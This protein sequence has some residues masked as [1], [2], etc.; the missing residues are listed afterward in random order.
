MQIRVGKRLGTWPDVMVRHAGGPRGTSVR[1]WPVRQRTSIARFQAR[2]LMECNE[3]G[4]GSK[5]VYPA[6]QP[7]CRCKAA[8]PESPP[9]PRQY[10]AGDYAPPP[11]IKATWRVLSAV[12]ALRRLEASAGDPPEGSERWGKAATCARLCASRLPSARGG[13]REMKQIMRLTKNANNT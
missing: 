3:T 4:W 10:C 6:T 5:V 2:C 9:P 13:G 7:G 12:D 11:A 1:D 8:P